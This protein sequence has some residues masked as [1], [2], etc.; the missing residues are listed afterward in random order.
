MLSPSL[1][2][3]VIFD[4]DGLIFDTEALYQKAL[5]GLAGESGFTSITQATVDRTVGLSWSSTRA[6]LALELPSHADVD[7]FI[8]AWTDSYE[9]LAQH[10][11]AL[12][13]GV[14]ELLDVLEACDI[15][16]A[17]AT[18]SYRDVALRYLAEFELLGRFDTIV[19]KED[20][21]HGKPAPEPFL[22]SAAQLQV[23][24]TRCWALED[25]PHG[26]RSAFDAGMATI[27]VPDLL[28]PDAETTALCSHIVSSLNEVV[29]LIQERR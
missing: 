4:M 2:K 22:T 3:A 13:P 24:S 27:M 19:A 18:G 28:T 15:A 10:Q 6:L 5:L 25:S 23:D 26:I 21:V 12:K 16:R 9:A 20:Y 14:T 29:S 1:P 8:E 17:V 7:A 11:L